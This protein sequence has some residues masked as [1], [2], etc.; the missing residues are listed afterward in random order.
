[1]FLIE[2]KKVLVV[3]LILSLMVLYALGLYWTLP[4]IPLMVCIFFDKELAWA[5][6]ILLIV[7][8]IGL[9]ILSL[10]GIVEFT[11]FPQALALYEVD[12]NL[13]F[14]FSVGNL[15][16]V[17]LMIAYP[18]VLISNINVLTL[19]DAFTIYSCMA[20]ALIGFFFLR[21]L[22]NIEGLTAF[23]RG[24]GL[25]LL[26]ILSV[27]MNGRLIY[28]FLGIVLIL[29]AE[30]KYK[31]HKKGVAALKISEIAGLILTMVSSGTMTIAFVFIFFMNVIQWIESKGKR[32]RRKLLAVNILLIYPFVDKFL[33]YFIR[34]LNK[35]IDYYGGGFNGAIRVMQHGFGRFFYT[36]NTN[37][38]FLLVA[39]A[40][41]AVLIN[42]IFF[43]EYIVRAKNPYLP[44]LLIANLCIYGGV[45]G[46]STG[47]L[48][49]LPVA[50]L[51]LSVYFRHIKI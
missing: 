29:D 19:D 48:A 17:R 7:F 1:M 28:A 21:L 5:D 23:N 40:L 37:I 14:W 4:Y 27:I 16:A 49:L 41:L 11:F 39:A 34:F 44:V 45:F 33:P 9:M 50:A 25:L 42:M 32:E 6:H 31:E 3:P 26:I 2:R 8:S 10:T 30:W 35:N 12:K 24:V 18:A 46:F 22:K 47:L 20:F 38:Y 51:I 43:I 15:H 13:F 36:D